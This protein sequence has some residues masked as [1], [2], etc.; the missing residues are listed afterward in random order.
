[1][2]VGGGGGGGGEVETHSMGTADE[3]RNPSLS[4]RYLI[5]P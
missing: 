2:C 3:R 1:M 5:V 4:F